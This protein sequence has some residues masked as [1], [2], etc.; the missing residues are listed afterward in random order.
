MKTI[1]DAAAAKFYRQHGYIILRGV[2]PASLIDRLRAMAEE[3]RT[4]AHRVNGPQAQRLQTL[5]DYITL[6]ALREFTQLPDFVAA[7]RSLLSARHFLSAP[8]TMTVL[9]QPSEHCWSTEWHRDLR[10]HIPAS[11]F[12]DVL[13]GRDWEELAL[14]FDNFNQFNCALYEDTSTWFVPGTHARMTDTPEELTAARAQNQAALENRNRARSEAEQ[15][16]FLNEYCAS[17]PGAVQVV[18]QAGDLVLY[19]NTAWHMGNY[20]P[21]RRRATLHG[22]ADTPEFADYKIELGK[23]LERL[24]PQ[25]EAARKAITAKR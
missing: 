2:I 3:A 25:I 4:I 13:G 19:R 11:V 7:I 23:T 12:Q 17:M 9:F 22:Q 6:D 1:I 18:L 5:G 14:S 10:D 15:E 24:K 20:V 8:E 16:I 21:Y